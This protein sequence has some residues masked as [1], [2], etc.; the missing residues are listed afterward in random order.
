MANKTIYLDFAAATPL[1]RAVFDAMK[2]Y[3]AQSFYNPSA[4]YLA[5]RTVR[6][7]L[8]NTRASI[9]RLLGARSAEIVFTAGATE[10]NNLAI[11]GVMRQFPEAELLVSTIEHESVLQPARLFE[12]K[13]IPTDR[14]GRVLLNKLS[15]LISEK[16]ALVS[17][18]YVNN[19]LGTVQPLHDI[20]AIVAEVR[21]QRL[22]T[23][24][25]IPLYLHS[26]A[27]QAPNCFDL[28]VSRMGV[29][30]LSLNGGKIYAPKQS[31]LLYLKAGTKVQPLILG[32][33][34]E[35]NM[36]SGT[37]NVAFS[38]GLAVAI[39]A[40]QARFRDEK[41]RLSS[42]RESLIKQLLATQNI[43][44][45]NGLAKNAAPHIISVTFRGYDNER[46][47]MELDEEGIQV[48]TGSA[49]SASSSQPSHVLSAIG[50]TDDEARSTLRISL[51]R[52]TTK[53]EVVRAARLINKYISKTKATA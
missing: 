3:L 5:A 7:D 6:R 36:R 4:N 34:Q 12:H 45:V 15:N 26:D 50:L 51:G 37:E 2:P 29:D 28:H 53:A 40:A 20:S 35:S 13:L 16:T 11:Q 18:G 48:A 19:E 17:V 43:A 9:A 39:E 27:A 33:G 1:D 24:N 32:G 42:L 22:E 14:A 8:E 30:M 38:V 47:M 10:A 23:G 52:Q 44:T 25:R 31:G 46:L 21:R 49:C 41:K